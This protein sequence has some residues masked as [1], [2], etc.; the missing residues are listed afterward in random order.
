MGLLAARFSSERGSVQLVRD[1]LVSLFDHRIEGI[2]CVIWAAILLGITCGVLGCFIVLRRQSLLGD[3]I[4]HSVLPGVCL[5]FII[6]GGRSTPVLLGGALLAGLVATWL[7]SVLQRTTRLK[8]GECM[9]VVFTGFYGLGIVALR[10]IQNHPEL[11][12]GQAGLERFLFG[13]IAGISLADV[14]YIAVVA[15]LT[16]ITVVVLWRKLAIWSFDEG[17]AHGIG[18]PTRAV[19]Y[20]LT[21][22][23]TLAI[24]ISIQAVGV[25]LVA[26]LLITPAATAYLV[27][28]RLHKMVLVAALGGAAAGVVGVLASLALSSGSRDMPTGATMVLAAAVVFALAFAFSPRHGLVPRLA[29]LWERRRRTQAENL[30]KTL[31][32]I[33]ERRGN[34]DRRFGISDVASARQ[35]SIVHVRRLAQIARR[36]GWLAGDVD[37]LVLTDSGLAEAQRVVRNHRL[38]ELFLTQEAKLAVDHVHADAEYIEHVLPRDVVARL[39]RML[40]NPKEDPHGRRIPL[41]VLEGGQK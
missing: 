9:G 5:G 8:P 37:P 22:L 26:A 35:E 38:W 21:F 27:T 40:E 7:I 32:Q 23:L 36:R 20:T 1:A 18:I 12:T 14:G 41:V 15:V 25:V 10:Y 29:R 34:S 4:G 19:E 24:I 3:A 2:D 39:E 11:G 6:A 17:F 30:L 28:D 31:Y 16:L 33:M 13:Q